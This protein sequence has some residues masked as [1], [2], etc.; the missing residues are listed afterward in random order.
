MSPRAR[1]QRKIRFKP[2]DETLYGRALELAVQDRVAESSLLLT[3]DQLRKALV[4]AQRE[5]KREGWYSKREGSN[6][7]AWDVAYEFQARRSPPSTLRKLG[8]TGV[9]IAETRG[10]YYVT[11]GISPR[12]TLPDETKLRRRR[13]RDLVPDSVRTMIPANE[14]GILARVGESGIL[15]SF[16]S[17]QAT[18]RIVAHWKTKG[19]ELD[20]VYVA[21]DKGETVLVPVEAK[22][23]G[24]RDALTK[25]QFARAIGAMHR[26]FPGHKVRP[27]GVKVLD[28]DSFLLVEFNDSSN[29]RALRARRVARFSFVEPLGADELDADE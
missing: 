12:I 25:P 16:L 21:I 7:N 5:G 11:K 3:A 8:Y 10:T 1:T 18:F 9:V 26:E 28:A 15:R 27:V 4:R 6:P 23:Q 22:S 29:W 20:E 14:Q 19:A 2:R 17:V 13:V 24:K